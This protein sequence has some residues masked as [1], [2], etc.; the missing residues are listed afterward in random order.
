MISDDEAVLTFSSQNPPSSS[1]QDPPSSPLSGR[2]SGERQ[3]AGKYVLLLED[4]GIQALHI[5]RMLDEFKCHLIGPARRTA[6]ALNL[7][8]MHPEIDVAIVD[9]HLEDAVATPAIDALAERRI[10]FVLITGRASYE[11]PASHDGI[12]L[13]KPF[14]AKDLRRSLTGTLFTGQSELS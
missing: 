12:V 13:A 10:P 9:L 3:L 14:T 2:D 4:N 6:F 8:E 1:S 11:L 7:I 5:L